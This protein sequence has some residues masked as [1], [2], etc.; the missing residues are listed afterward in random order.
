MVNGTKDP[1]RN[2][3]EEK[4]HSEKLRRI[5]A[6][7]DALA[8]LTAR[9]LA[10]RSMVAGANATSSHKMIEPEIQRGS[11]EVGQPLHRLL[12]MAGSNV[13]LDGPLTIPF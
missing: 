4:F 10:N 7:R 2:V 8:R 13:T 5:C 11:Q 12:G 9:R 3:D 6:G 1:A